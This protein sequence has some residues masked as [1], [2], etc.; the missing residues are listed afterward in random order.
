[1]Y[2]LQVITC[3]LM[4]STC[5]YCCSDKRSGLTAHSLTRPD[6]ERLGC[7]H[8]PGFLTKATTMMM[9]TTARKRIVDITH[10]ILLIVESLA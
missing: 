8:I 3:T 10:L 7:L 6:D 2:I 1:M 5:T 4:T 9:V